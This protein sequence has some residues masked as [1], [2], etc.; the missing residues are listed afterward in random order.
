MFLLLWML[1]YPFLEAY[2]SVSQVISQNFADDCSSNAF[3]FSLSA[4]L[5]IN[6]LFYR[7]SCYIALLKEKYPF[8]D[9]CN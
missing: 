3:L 7:K 1:N 5:I 8:F 6:G 2:M 4:N 9:I